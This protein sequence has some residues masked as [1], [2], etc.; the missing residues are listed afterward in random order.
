MAICQVS[1]VS[2]LAALPSPHNMLRRVTTKILYAKSWYYTMHAHP[3]AV[4][5][6]LDARI[7]SYFRD[8]DGKDGLN[9]NANSQSLIVYC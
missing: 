5:E 2:F 4:L 3:E 7:G 6:D 9:A 8:R 1:V